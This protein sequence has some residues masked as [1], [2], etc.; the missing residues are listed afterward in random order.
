[1]FNHLLTITLQLLWDP[2]QGSRKASVL[3][4]ELPEQDLTPRSSFHALSLG[5]T[6]ATS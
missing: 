4:S 1:M 2:Q 5:L 6:P 3:W